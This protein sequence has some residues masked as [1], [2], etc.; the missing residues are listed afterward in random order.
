[1]AS[2]LWDLS[3]AQLGRIRVTSHASDAQK[4]LKKASTISAVIAE[5]DMTAIGAMDIDQLLE[6]IP[7]SST[8]RLGQKD[9]GQYSVRGIALMD[10]SQVLCS[11]TVFPTRIVVPTKD[12]MFG[13]LCLCR[14]EHYYYQAKQS[15][16]KQSNGDVGD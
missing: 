4:S 3:L 11:S 6:T 7:N 9:V 13:V 8:D 14:R 12:V 10:N 16:A 5:N 1:M 2:D 15:K